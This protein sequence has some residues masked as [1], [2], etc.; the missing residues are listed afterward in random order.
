V[1]KQPF[2]IKRPEDAGGC[3]WYAAEAERPI[4][5]CLAIQ[6]VI[7]ALAFFLCCCAFVFELFFYFLGFDVSP[8]EGLLT[9]SA[10]LVIEGAHE[11]LLGL[12]LIPD[13]GSAIS[14]LAQYGF[15][16]CLKAL[17][18]VDQLSTLIIVEFNEAGHIVPTI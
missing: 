17:S 14:S 13:H 1:A 18:G 3:Q 4:D 16:P 2:P 12:H 15:P 5:C 9:S 10:V 7:K 11:I 8:T 6:G